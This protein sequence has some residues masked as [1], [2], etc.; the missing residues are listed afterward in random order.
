MNAMFVSEFSPWWIRNCLTRMSNRFKNYKQCRDEKHQQQAKATWVQTSKR[1]SS[2]LVYR[3]NAFMKGNT[4]GDEWQSFVAYHIN[5]L[6]RRYDSIYLW[7]I[8]EYYICEKVNNEDFFQDMFPNIVWRF[9]AIEE[10]VDISK[11]IRS[12]RNM[13]GIRTERYEWDDLIGFTRKKYRKIWNNRQPDDQLLWHMCY[14]ANHYKIMKYWGYAAW[15]SRIWQNKRK[16]ERLD[17]I[18]IYR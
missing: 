1:A 14:R 18:M 10:A 11:R 16:I 2:K 3:Y 12:T 15:D 4:Q 5:K 7:S 8:C 13:G 6:N 9:K 17:H